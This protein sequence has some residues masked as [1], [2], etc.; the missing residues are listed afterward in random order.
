M[1]WRHSYCNAVL[2]KHLI[3]LSPNKVQANWPSP[4]FF[5][6]KWLW[7]FQ[8]SQCK[9]VSS[10]GEPSHEFPIVIQAEGQ[11][12]FRHVCQGDTDGSPGARWHGWSVLPVPT[13]SRAC[14]PPLLSG[15]AAAEELP[16]HSSEELLLCCGG[17]I[18]SFH[19]HLSYSSVFWYTGSIWKWTKKQECGQN[20]Q[21]LIFILCQNRIPDWSNIVFWLMCF[22]KLVADP[23]WEWS[24]LVDDSA[25]ENIAKIVFLLII[26]NMPR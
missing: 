3:V 18:I 5:H 19:L 24:L 22:R 12:H 10:P 8:K 21:S 2:W 17:I 14:P 4:S 9:A 7:A 1:N 15:P 25:G 16:S 26:W 13:A 23:D 11:S 20:F 6:G